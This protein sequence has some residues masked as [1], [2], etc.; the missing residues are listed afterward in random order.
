MRSVLDDQLL[1]GVAAAEM[2]LRPARGAWALSDGRWDEAVQCVGQLCEL[3]GGTADLL[4]PV[5]DGSVHNTYLSLLRDSEIDGVAF[6]GLGVLAPNVPGRLIHRAPALLALGTADREKLRPLR[7]AQL[8]AGDPWELSYLCALG[9]LPERPSLT[10]MRSLNLR[11]DLS[12][13]DVIRTSHASVVNPGV[14][15]LMA[16]LQSTEGISP[17]SANRYL[18]HRKPAS[19]VQ[20]AIDGW[21]CDPRAVGRQYGASIISVYTP[22]NVP[23]L[24]LNWNL[25]ALHGWPAGLP[26]AV[27]FLDTAQATA[28]LLKGVLSS[29]GMGIRG[30]PTLLAS[31]SLDAAVLDELAALLPQ[32][33]LEVATI[34]EVLRPATPPSRTTEVAL[35]YRDGSSILSTR[36]DRDRQDLA[37]IDRIRPELDMRLSVTHAEHPMPP[38]RSLSGGLSGAFT[39][40]RLVLEAGRDRLATASWP[41]GFSLL[42]ARAYDSGLHASPSASGRTAIA[43]LKYIG[44]LADVVWLSHKPLVELLYKKAAASGMGWWKQRSTAQAGIVSQASSDPEGV[45]ERLLAAI[46][47][48]SV[49]HGG[50]SASTLTFGELVGVLGGRD[51]AAAWLEWSE[52]RSL[53]IR[54]G[55]FKC[56]ICQF[57]GWRPLAEIAPPIV[58]PGCRHA[59]ERPFGPTALNFTYR[60]SET[61]RRAIEND[62][63]Q[64]LFAMRSLVGYLE[65]SAD[66]VV[67]AHPGV[68]F[69]KGDKGAE[70]DV[71]VL[72]EG[73][74][75]VPVEMKLHSTALRDHDVDQLDLLAGW[76][77]TKTTVL[78]TADDDADLAPEFLAAAQA[79]SSMYRR[80]LSGD[81]LFDPSPRVTMESRYPGPDVCQPIGSPEIHRRTVDGREEAF[82]NLLRSAGPHLS[83]NRD[84]TAVALNI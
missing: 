36:S 47:D 21:I 3:W 13:D 62:S 71:V 70:A 57:Q 44:S 27:P 52:R 48:V 55:N 51:S 39:G 22:G 41:S 84:H 2:Q 34:E 79:N 66:R 77:G 65:S 10:M 37:A 53:L 38:V 50:E 35:I 12:Y 56:E 7:V 68:D 32:E 1:E 14:A 33:S 83:S 40:G 64:H 29:A 23:D 74:T 16:R 46:A 75:V 11:E 28:D 73:G 42:Q 24:C 25:R 78:A 61:L 18:L 45:T 9:M 49:S 4:V 26:L 8:K 76:L 5:V 72:L 31:A 6:D 59:N 58:C 20:A 30:W 80:L 63:I 60:L 54:G 81:D 43:L 15:D 19:V 67:G 17:A 69:K 82:L